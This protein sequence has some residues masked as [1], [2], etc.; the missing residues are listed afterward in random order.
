SLKG[1][2]SVSSAASL[3]SAGMRLQQLL[4]GSE[5][6]AHG[7]A[8][9]RFCHFRQFRKTWGDA[10]ETILRILAEGMRCACGRQLDAG[11][12][13]QLHDALR[14]AVQHF[15]RNEITALR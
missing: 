9:D 8:L 4:S 10:D 15:E 7:D 14:T 1:R 3:R 13:R 2:K 11:F 12:F 6:H 5:Q